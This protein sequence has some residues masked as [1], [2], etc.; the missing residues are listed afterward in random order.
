MKLAVTARKLKEDYCNKNFL[1]SKTN[2]AVQQQQQQ[3]QRKRE[4]QQQLPFPVGATAINMV[5]KEL[6][7]YFRMFRTI[8]RV[9]CDDILL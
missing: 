4:Q 1:V 8:V 2:D 5:Y 7:F 9:P 3:Q 6:P